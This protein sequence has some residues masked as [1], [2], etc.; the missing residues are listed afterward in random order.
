MSCLH[1]KSSG[2]R[3]ACGYMCGALYCGEECAR[4]HWATL[5]SY[6]HVGNDPLTRLARD[7][8]AAPAGGRTQARL[9][10]YVVSAE[11]I[12]ERLELVV[13]MANALPGPRIERDPER[14]YGLRADRNYVAGELV[15]E[16]GGVVGDNRVEG[17]YAAQADAYTTIDGHH[18]FRL[19]QKGRWINESD[20]Q[21]TSV[22]VKLGRRVVALRNIAEEEWL[23]ADYGEQYVRDY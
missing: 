14:G 6:M 5:H 17:D 16:Y 9:A 3:F 12:D 10:S 11:D 19:A 1:C 22:N 21:R 18:G 4:A 15:T 23:F 7:I 20:A 13:R 8:D 2:V